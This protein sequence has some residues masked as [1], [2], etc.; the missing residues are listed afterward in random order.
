MRNNIEHEG[1][2]PRIKANHTYIVKMEIHSQD[3]IQY[4]KTQCHNVRTIK[5]I[6]NVKDTTIV[7]NDQNLTQKTK[8]DMKQ[9][10]RG[11]KTTPKVQDICYL[12][13]TPNST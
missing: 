13:Y 5:Y 3:T 4:P 10:R 2:T 7:Q 1:K 6:S 9:T 8:Q 12:K 11:S